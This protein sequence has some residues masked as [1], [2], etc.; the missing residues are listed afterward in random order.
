M[1]LELKQ[2][3]CLFVPPLVKGPFYYVF[4]ANLEVGGS[5]KPGEIGGKGPF[6]VGKG[7]GQWCV[8]REG[9]KGD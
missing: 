3:A 9:G 4:N 8:K 2:G 7:L 5:N 6:S 1:K